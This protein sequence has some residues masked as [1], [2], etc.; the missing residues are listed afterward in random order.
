MEPQNNTEIDSTGNKPEE[1]FFLL[2]KNWRRAE[3]ILFGVILFLVSVYFVL[4][5][6]AVQNWL[7]RRVIEQVSLAL[8][9]KV[10]L[11]RINIE[12]FDNVLLEDFFIEDSRGDT[13]IY[14]RKLGVGMKSN[15]FTLLGKEIEIEQIE[16]AGA[17]IYSRRAEGDTMNTIKTFLSRIPGKKNPGESTAIR[18]RIQHLNLT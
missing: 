5:S 2:R 18:L 1:K 14:V 17:R 3:N 15:F 16:L 8:N 4:Q 10:D 6:P 11:R 7:V 12:F 13:L 9:T